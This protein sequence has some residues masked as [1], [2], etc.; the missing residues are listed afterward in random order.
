MA[1]GMVRPLSFRQT[2]GAG[3]VTEA[4]RLAT[5]FIETAYES[6]FKVLSWSAENLD[7]PVHLKYVGGGFADEVTRQRG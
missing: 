1:D 7:Q 3:S 2:V 5:R 4:L 6:G